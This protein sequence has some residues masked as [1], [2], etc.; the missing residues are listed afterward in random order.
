[1]YVREI[2]PERP[3]TSC[4]KNDIG[5]INKPI[6]S[7]S[8][9]RRP[10]ETLDK[11]IVCGVIILTVSPSDSMRGLGAQYQAQPGKLEALRQQGSLNSHPK[12]VLDELFL[13]G[14][15]FDPHDLVQVKYEMLRRVQAEGQ[16]VTQAAEAFGFSRPSFYQAQSVFEQS[17]LPGLVPHKR[18]PKEA[19]KLTKEVVEFLQQARQDDTSLR[20]P[21]LA[22]MVKDRFGVLVHP[23]TIER[24]LERSQ[25]KRQ[26]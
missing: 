15:F 9:Q 26:K 1:M 20:A 10:N 6:K 23:R 8:H 18:G 11:L 5:S 3:S 12:E 25:K 2:T 13:T 7:H 22:R 21:A 17:G 16:S 14:D 24:G 4:C 19:H